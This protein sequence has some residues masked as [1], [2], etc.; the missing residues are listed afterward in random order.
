MSIILLIDD[1]PGMGDLV[2]M[3]LDDLDVSVVQATTLASARSIAS[4]S[5]PDVI[6]LDVNLGSDGDGLEHLPKLRDEPGLS[7]VPVVVFSVHASRERE[8]RALGAAGFVPKPFKAA[9]LR[10]ELDPLLT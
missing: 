10:S 5:A 6:M 4:E 7:E 9:T 3:F 1:E 8:A 2:R